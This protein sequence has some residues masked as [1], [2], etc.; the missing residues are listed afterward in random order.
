[1][2]GRAQDQSDS[3]DNSAIW[4]SIFS[5][6]TFPQV[7]PNG[8]EYHTQMKLAAHLFHSTAESITDRSKGALAASKE[9]PDRGDKLQSRPSVLWTIRCLLDLLCA[10]FA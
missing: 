6:G 2:R 7:S 1:V 10:R 8:G 9:G 3:A 4:D 5:G